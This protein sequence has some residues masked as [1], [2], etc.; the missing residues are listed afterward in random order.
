MK[1]V[2]V[3]GGGGREHAL[4]WRLSQEA[5]V[6]VAP[7]NGGTESIGT[8]HR[9]N[10]TDVRATVAL[11]KTLRADLV[12]VGPEAPLALGLVDALEAAGIAAFGPK[13][14][15][16][17]LEAS[18]VFSKALMEE[19]GVPTADARSFTDAAEARTYIH[20]CGR[21]M[22]VKADGLAAGK[23]VVVAASADEAA[24]AVD[25]MLEGRAFGDA[26]ARVLVEERL[27][28]REV[29]FHA[30]CAGD[31]VV[32]LATAQDHKR[33][34]DG[35]EGPNTGGMGAYSPVP[36][37]G[38]DL[39]A[40]IVNECV[41]PILK[42]LGARGI[43]F[44]GVLFVGLMVLDDDLRVLEY[45][46][47]FGD[48]ECQVLMARWAG[49]LLPV[50]ENAAK[51]TLQSF[52][53]TWSAPAATAVVLASGGYPRAYERGKAIELGEPRE[54]AQLFHAGTAYRG[55]QLETA[56]GRVLAV[57]GTGDTVKASTD[58]AYGRA[59]SV[60]FEGKMLRN[61]I[62]WQAR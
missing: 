33:A 16:A 4:A 46:V 52:E 2:L 56:G 13:R 38:P 43:E 25:Q 53:P 40:R 30:I 22:V 48:P 14:E 57:V 7:G 24:E 62:A 3:V 50:L 61:D 9:L 21:P 6:H 32:P 12:V 49:A 26:G 15:A 27:E 36:F 45:N 19:A 41:R 11:A 39:E 1:R 18:K 51:G 60:A 28:G 20:A 44:R 55:G 34:Y 42:A 10:V 58:V 35:D 54:G 37:V 47:R 8:N 17:Q 31:V 23:G 59:S 29:S 5:E